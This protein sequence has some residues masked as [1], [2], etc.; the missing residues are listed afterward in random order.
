MIIVCAWC[1]KK[2]G[3]KPPYEDKSLTHSMCEKC[4]KK[5]KEKK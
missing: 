4:Y 3:E 2:M 1:G 5:W